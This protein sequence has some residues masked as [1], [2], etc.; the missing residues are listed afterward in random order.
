MHFFYY[1][2]YNFGLVLLRKN[3]VQI[4]RGLRLIYRSIRSW[5]ADRGRG[6]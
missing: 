5:L 6:D 3:G 4:E 2:L 1:W